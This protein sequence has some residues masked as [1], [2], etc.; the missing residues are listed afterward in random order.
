M[1]ILLYSLN[2]RRAYW[3]AMKMNRNR[4]FVL[5]FILATAAVCLW[6]FRF[7][8][9]NRSLE[10]GKYTMRRNILTGKECYFIGEL[11]RP[12]IEALKLSHC[13]VQ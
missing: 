7:Q 12:Q 6:M 5:L 8:Y 10:G 4:A 13:A 9:Y 2:C 1:T 3:L 11:K